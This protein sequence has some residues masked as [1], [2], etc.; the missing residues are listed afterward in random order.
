M[1]AGREE[2]RLPEVPVLPARVRVLGGVGDGFWEKSC[3]L[4]GEVMGE[5]ADCCL[6]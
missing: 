4:E 1:D 3:R 6:E 2:G 5:E